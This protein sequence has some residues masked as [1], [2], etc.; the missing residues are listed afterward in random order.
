MEQTNHSRSFTLLPSLGEKS[1]DFGVVKAF[2][3]RFLDQPYGVGIYR[4]A[5]AIEPV[6][7]ICGATNPFKII[8]TAIGFDFIL[9]MDNFK[10]K[11]I[12]NE[13]LGHKAVNHQGFHFPAARKF[14]FRIPA[15]AQA[16]N[17]SVSSSPSFWGIY[18]MV[19]VNKSIKASDTTEVANLITLIPDSITPFLSRNWIKKF[20]TGAWEKL[21][22]DSLDIKHFGFSFSVWRAEVSHQIS[23]VDRVLEN[24]W[25]K[26]AL[27]ITLAIFSNAAKAS[28]AMPAGNLVHA[29]VPG[30]RNPNLGIVHGL[31]PVLYSFHNEQDRYRHKRHAGQV[32]KNI[33]KFKEM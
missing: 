29:F 8:I 25:R 19:T 9:M 7:D 10:A 20:W 24:F 21:R 18:G 11:R 2:G 3:Q 6:L 32:N 14:N 31:S 26:S 22:Y 13:G 28:N 1:E 23:V 5:A 15:G 4:K 33:S 27:K 16:D 17:H 12:W 30:N